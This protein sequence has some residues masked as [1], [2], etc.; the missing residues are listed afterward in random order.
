MRS[1]IG[2]LLL[3]LLGLFLCALGALKAPYAAGWAGDPGTLTV[4][5]CRYTPGDR[6]TDRPHCYGDFAPDDGSYAEGP[7]HLDEKHDV[8]EKVRL[9]R[10]GAASYQHL[11]P[12]V[13]LGWFSL[14]L[15]GVA[16]VFRWALPGLLVDTRWA[17]SDRRPQRLV[18]L[19]RLGGFA[20]WGAILCFGIFIAL[21]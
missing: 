11:A 20:F 15:G 18:R 19:Q 17:D 10:K 9:S 12:T 4:R 21:D 2:S 6:G 8:G 1:R 14:L 3:L 16:C 7:V 5:Y 13:A